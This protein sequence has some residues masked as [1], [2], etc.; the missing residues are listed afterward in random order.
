ML[1]NS[2]IDRQPLTPESCGTS[3]ALGVPCTDSDGLN[4]DENLARPWDWNGT[5]LHAVV[6]WKRGSAAKRELFTPEFLTYPM[7]DDSFHGFWSGG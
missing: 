2:N 1:Q 7:N 5:L 4:L 6:L 3:E